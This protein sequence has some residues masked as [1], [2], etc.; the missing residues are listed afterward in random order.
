[1][2]EFRNW[3]SEFEEVVKLLKS[4]LPPKMPQSVAISAVG[5][6]NPRDS[7]RLQAAWSLG[8]IGPDAVGA[9][10]VLVAKLLD[11]RV[12]IQQAAAWAIMKIG[13]LQLNAIPAMLEIYR[14]CKRAASNE[15]SVE[16]DWYW[17][18]P[19]LLRALHDPDESV[20]ISGVQAL[21]EIAPPSK[22][23]IRALD[24]VL[25]YRSD[26]VSSIAGWAIEEIGES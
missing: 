5:L 8:K 20:A 21:G 9:I 10:P 4:E 24:N 12:E 22:A 1:M 16:E 15:A 2:A 19:L 18:I 7:V 11:P 3:K 17:T 14:E 6:N 23:V 26:D 13:P 25:Q